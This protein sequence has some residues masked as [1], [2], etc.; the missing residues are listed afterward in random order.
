MNRESRYVTSIYHTSSPIHPLGEHLL[1]LLEKGANV[2]C[3]MYSL[4]LLESP[5]K[6]GQRSKHNHLYLQTFWNHYNYLGTLTLISMK[7][8]VRYTVEFPTCHLHPDFVGD[9]TDCKKK[10]FWAR[11]FP[12]LYCKLTTYFIRND[13]FRFQVGPFISCYL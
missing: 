4:S 12:Q 9:T 7:N 11:N 8:N 13:G 2:I 10:K 5:R 1:Y 6:I 3:S